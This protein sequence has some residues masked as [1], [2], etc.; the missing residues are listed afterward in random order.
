MPDYGKTKIYYIQ[1]GDQRYYGHTTVPLNTRT[2]GH[3]CDSKRTPDI[4]L[5]AA[6]REANMDI[7]KLKLHHV[8]DYPCE[9][10]Q[11]AKE[12]EK[13]WIQQHGHLN[14]CIPNRTPKEYREDHKERIRERVRNFKNNNV[15]M[16]QARRKA[17]YI[18]NHDKEAERKR[19]FYQNNKEKFKQYYEQNKEAIDQRRKEKYQ[20][21]KDVINAKKREKAHAAKK[22]AA[23]ETQ[24]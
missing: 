13:W 16:M 12:R 8:E 2:A 19:I 1:V 4:K 14:R 17:K 6:I 23:D 20:Q 22:Q 24:N 9:S 21:N 7:T 3:K 18:A 5:Y 11:Q 10:L 15:E